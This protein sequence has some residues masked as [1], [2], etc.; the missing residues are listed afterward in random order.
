VI[1][2]PVFK[3]PDARPYVFAGHFVP[4][5]DRSHAFVLGHDWALGTHAG[6]DTAP[7]VG[8][9]G[10]DFADL[11]QIGDG[12]WVRFPNPPTDVVPEELRE[13]TALDHDVKI[14]SLSAED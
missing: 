6:D 3:H 5:L 9:V 12:H 13:A 8:G 2:R 7:W 11:P 14:L 10:G 1:H 4:N